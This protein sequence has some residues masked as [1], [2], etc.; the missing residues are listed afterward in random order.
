MNKRTVTVILTAKDPKNPKVGRRFGNN[1]PGE[2]CGFP[3]DTAKWLVD[4]GHAKYAYSKK[5]L[6]DLAKNDEKREKAEMA[7]VD[8]I[9]AENKEIKAELATIKQLLTGK[10]TK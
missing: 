3:E 6:E 7:E 1:Q 8:R 5:E 2:K 9:K 10:E 4:N